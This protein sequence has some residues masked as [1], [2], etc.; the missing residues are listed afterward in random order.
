MSK[1]LDSTGLLIYLEAPSVER[2]FL[3]SIK[4]FALIQLSQTEN[5]KSIGLLKPKNYEKVSKLALLDN[6]AI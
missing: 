2:F 3:L 4:S 1:I 6:L 5:Q